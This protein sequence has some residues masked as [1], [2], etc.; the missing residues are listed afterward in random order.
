[1]TYLFNRVARLAPGNLL[2][3]MAW[4]VK[5]T[6]RVHNRTSRSATALTRR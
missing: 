2:D 6:E 3:S 1:M 4:A 5:M